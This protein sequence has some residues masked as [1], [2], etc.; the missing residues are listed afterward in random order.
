MTDKTSL[1]QALRRELDESN[2]GLLALHAELSE[3]HDELARARTAAEQATRDK[4]DFLARMGQEIRSPMNA[5]LGFTSLLR[6]TELTTEQVEYAEAA[7]TAGN[8]LLGVINSI[9]DLSKIEAGFLELEDVPYDLFACVEDA[10]DMLAA[11]AKEKNL[12]LAA[13]FAAS[14]PA[15]VVGDSLRLRQILACTSGSGPASPARPE[16]P[17]RRNCTGRAETGTSGLAPSAAENWALS[18]PPSPPAGRG[19]ARAPRPGHPSWSLSTWAASG[20]AR[21]ASTIVSARAPGAMPSWTASA[22][23]P[24]C[25]GPPSPAN[26]RRSTWTISCGPWASPFW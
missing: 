8:H 16:G 11:R 20:L 14:L 3:Q 4:A 9:L 2:Q 6:A 17:D 25:W 23:P 10:I 5:I 1:A 21:W 7:E 26:R 13:L 18:K 15:T 19:A 22:Q 24:V 12:A